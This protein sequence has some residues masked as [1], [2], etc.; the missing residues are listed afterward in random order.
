MSIKSKKNILAFIPARGGS[1]RF[2]KKNI[3]K[4]KN[5]PLIY[6][7]IKVCKDAKLFNN[8]V[9]SSENDEILSYS[10]KYHVNV[11]KRSKKMAG[12]QIHELEALQEYLNNLSSPNLPNLICLIYPTSILLSVKDILKSYALID[13]DKKADVVMGVSRYSYHPYKALKQNRNGYLKP[14]F[15]SEINKRSQGY[16]NLLASN[17][18]FYWH[19]TKSLLE[20]KYSNLYGKNL[21]GYIMDYNFPIDID[22][23]EDLEKIKLNYKKMK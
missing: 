8:V 19:R 3:A 22:Y 6:Y 12:D 16:P 7:P 11:I 13:K 5:K 9:V 18:T 23:P 10:K 17:G 21:L 2:P 4:F 20:K 1:K 15:E 14:I